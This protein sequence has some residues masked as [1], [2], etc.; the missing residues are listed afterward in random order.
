[1]YIEYIDCVHTEFAALRRV[2]ASGVNGPW[3]ELGTKLRQLCTFLFAAASPVVVANQ[4]IVGSW[5]QDR[6]RNIYLP[7][8]YKLTLYLKGLGTHYP[9]L[10]AVFTSVVYTIREDGPWTRA[11]MMSEHINYVL[12]DTNFERDRQTAQSSLFKAKHNLN[13]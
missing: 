3:H 8:I 2:A 6:A 12:K 11:V 10:R 4:F 9:C 13:R 5:T 7:C 1:V